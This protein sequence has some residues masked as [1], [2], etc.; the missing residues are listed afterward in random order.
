MSYDLGEVLADRGRHRLHEFDG[1]RGK[2]FALLLDALIHRQELRE[3]ERGAHRD[4]ARSRGFGAADVIEKIIEKLERGLLRVARL[5]QLIQTFDLAVGQPQQALDR[6]TAFKRAF[7]QRLDHR[8]DHP[9][10]LEHRLVRRNLLDLARHGRQDLEVLLDT[11]TA[12][13]ANEPDLETRAQAPPPLLDRQ[14]LLAGT[15]GD[16]LGLLGRTSN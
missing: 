4:R 15:R 6:D 16:G 11:L 3:A 10:Q 1:G 2:T 14:R 5:A 13:P 12:D 9:P 7:L 8:A